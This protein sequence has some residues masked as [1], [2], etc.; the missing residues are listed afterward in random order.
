[1]FDYRQVAVRW[2][3]AQAMAKKFSR[4]EDGALIIFSLFIFICMLMFG[5]I[6]V[7]V[8]V[9]ENERTHIQNSTDTAVLA[10]ANL[11]QT[12]DPKLVVQDNLAKKGINVA[13]DDITV[14]EVGTAPVIT[15]R[16]VSVTVRGEYDTMLM[17]AVGV[18]TLPYNGFSEA[19]ESVNDIEVSLIL[20]VSGSM[21]WNSKL[22]NMQAAAKDFVTNI[23][24]GADDN[25]VSLS[26][27]PYATQVSVGPE[28]MAEFNTQYN[29][30]YSY[31]VNFGST[32][33]NRTRILDSN[34]LERTA[35]FDP[36]RNYRYGQ[37]LRYPVCRDEAAFR[38]TPWSNNVTALNTQIDA[39]TAGGNT[40]IDVAVK[41][42][43]ALLDPTMNGRLNS[44][45]AN[46][47][48]EIDT[49][50]L[51]RPRPY[52]Y[53]DSLKFMVVMTDG[54]N[55]SQPYLRGQYKSG[56]SPYFRETATGD[57]WMEA[58]EPGDR[59]ND[60]D[61]YEDWYN[62]SDRNWDD[63]PNNTGDLGVAFGQMSWLDAWANM[64]MSWR[65]YANYHQ[66]YDADDY[67]DS[68]T[69]AYR[70]IG[71]AEK[72]RRLDSI[73]SAA[74]AQGIIVFAVGFEVTDASADVMR[75]CASTPSHFYRV[76]GLDIKYAF[77]SIA[78]Q[79]N[80]L[81]LTQ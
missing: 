7:D 44:L 78:N 50:F 6:A 45:I 68:F 9:Y 13:L 16:Q 65:A 33:F 37:S 46:P 4:D 54:I 74:K 17:N 69:D 24:A 55:T 21:G 47:S 76:E 34:P 71:A 10:A 61:Y 41:W 1:M 51:H 27:V 5:G 36:W 75:S 35:Q 62:V 58:E 42:G 20:D 67:Y 43:A 49:E 60:S 12:I 38:V 22:S 56:V 3:C 57:I 77:S 81:K 25:R 19:S 79:I 66:S 18:E 15:G 59:D 73:C 31:C 32:E 8:M 26:L 48:V 23:L 72:D 52:D 29:H 63:A 2:A 70:W 28:L 11:N 14:T 39:L 80:R 53:E 40:S 64:T 30:N